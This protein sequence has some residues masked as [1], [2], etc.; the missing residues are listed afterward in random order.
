MLP[1]D[2][3]EGGVAPEASAHATLVHPKLGTR[4]A[5]TTP[6]ARAR[7]QARHALANRARHVLA[8][9]HH[10]SRAM[11]SIAPDATH[12]ARERAERRV[13]DDD[14]TSA[15]LVATKVRDASS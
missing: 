1:R 7:R 5:R 9:H 6:I 8:R 3:R 12:Y 11:G 15:R 4:V 10:A 13:V 14:G 2:E